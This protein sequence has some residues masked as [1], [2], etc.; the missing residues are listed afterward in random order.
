MTNTLT[1]TLYKFPDGKMVT[2]HCEGHATKIT[3]VKE[4]RFGQII[5]KD[6]DDK[7]WFEEMCLSI[8]TG[9]ENVT[10]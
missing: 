10:G 8:I 1:E 6:E 4:N 2:P 7:W 3:G 9:T 5:L